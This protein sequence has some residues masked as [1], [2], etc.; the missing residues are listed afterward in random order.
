[1]QSDLQ[2]FL[3]TT[4]HRKPERILYYFTLT[5]DI[6][7]RI[8]DYLKGADFKQHYNLFI[9]YDIY[10]QRPSNVV[11]P[12]YSRYWENEHLSPATRINSI[13]VAEVPGDFYH[14]WRYL[15]PLSKANSLRDIEKYPIEDM[16]TWDMSYMSE[17]VERAHA[18]GQT[19]RGW[20]GH[21][22]E[23]AWQ[24]R[25]Y[26]QFLMDMIERP[27]WAQCLLDK[28]AEQCLVRAKAYA[29]ADVDWIQCGDDVANQNTLMFSPLLWEKMIYS[30]WKEIWHNVKLINKNA[31]IW[32]HSDGN[33]IDIIGKLVDAGVNILNPLQPECL[34]IDSVYRSY[35]R[36]LTFD[37]C[38]G[39]QTTM[40][41]GT[42]D[43][44]RAR[45]REVIKKYGQNG[46]LILSPTH[47]LEPEVPIENIEAFV[48]ACKDFAKGL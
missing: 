12:D 48:N 29:K 31:R 36:H 35:G 14:F 3:D 22:Y 32:Y 47:I 38:I 43:D 20:V 1:M 46:G 4:E 25:G 15:S 39:T 28:L 18:Q 5:D 13:G 16:S 44:V 23:N 24:I 7:R 21:I 19:V 34:D 30:K 41:L 37:G 45:V 11:P 40:P 26:E 33:I 9:P 27:S 42:P 6:G 17:T 2:I 8:T 10:P